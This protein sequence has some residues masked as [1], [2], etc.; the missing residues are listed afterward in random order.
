MSQTPFSFFEDYKPQMGDFLDDTIRGLNASPKKIQPHYLY[1]GPG[2]KLFEDICQADEYYITRTEIGLIDSIA[3][4]LAALAGKQVRLVEFGMGEGVKTR[5]ILSALDQ[6]YGFVGIDISREQ[7]EDNITAI[8]K[9]FPALEIG[10]VCADF[11]KL[12]PLPKAKEVAA[13][14]I[15]FF[16]G[17]TI[18]NYLPAEQ[19]QLLQ[20]MKK[21][22]TTENEK[23]SLIIGVDL[24]KSEKQLTA[25]YDD[26][27]GIT[28]AFSMNLLTRMKRELGAKLDI[29][30][31]KHEATYKTDKAC[32]EICLRS[33]R[34]QTIEIG[35]HSFTLD[36][37]EP[38]YTEKAYKWTPKLFQALAEESGWHPKKFW[39][40]EQELFSIHWLDSE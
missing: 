6:P 37:G 20:A 2:A 11:F 5:Q 23:A 29:D 39:C 32:I 31:F 7:L 16:P 24:Q 19:K 4:E 1:D 40:D 30:G 10:G 21:A 15:G 33:L 17:S 22:L 12:K 36:K 26:A 3:A 8:A 28:A 27:K 38:I 14:S 18:G 35:E 34:A 13:H 9:D 25:A